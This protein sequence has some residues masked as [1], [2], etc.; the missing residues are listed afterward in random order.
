M[1]EREGGRGG[2]EEGRVGE[3]EREREGGREGERKSTVLYTEV[4]DTH[5]PSLIPSPY[6]NPHTYTHTHPPPPYTVLALV[7]KRMKR[8]FKESNNS[9]LRRKERALENSP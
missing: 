5:T 2:R 1:K 6:P 9:W 3:R 4:V 7:V 8:T